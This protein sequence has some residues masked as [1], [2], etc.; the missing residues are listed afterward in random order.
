MLTLIEKISFLLLAVFSL[1]Y[2]GIGF[3]RVYKAIVRG[4]PDSR[5]DHLLQRASRALWIVLTQQS[6]FKKRPIISLLHALVFYGFVYYGLVNIVDAW[7][8]FFPFRARGGIWHLFN[9]LADLLTAGVLVGILG[10]AIRRF[11]V[12]PKDFHFGPSVPLQERVTSGIL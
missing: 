3:Y 1:S 10:L 6:V 5:F 2:A 11:L 8:G 12:R 7:E 4:R 9:L